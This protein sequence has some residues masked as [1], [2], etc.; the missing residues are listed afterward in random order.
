MEALDS[1]VFALRPG[2]KFP[3]IWDS[4]P[5]ALLFSNFFQRS[6]NSPELGPHPTDNLLHNTQ[7]FPHNK[8]HIL[9]RYTHFIRCFKKELFP[10]FTKRSYLFWPYLQ[11][12]NI[13]LDSTKDLSSSL[14]YHLLLFLSCVY[15]FVLYYISVV[16]FCSCVKK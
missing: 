11:R 12:G 1:F 3:L 15:Y 10:T 6:Y 16:I 9:R 4:L 14:M 13:Y 2:R 7:Y 5:T 8:C